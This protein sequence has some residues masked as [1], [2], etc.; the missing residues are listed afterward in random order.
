MLFS[1]QAA[2]R[3]AVTSAVAGLAIALAAPL[4]AD[5]A[6][7]AIVCNAPY[8]CIQTYSVSSQDAVI[9]AWADTES[10]YG[11]FYAD[12]YVGY[13]ITEFEFS[14]IQT[15]PAGGT[16]YSFTLDCSSSFTYNVQA[17]DEDTGDT[18][19]NINFTIHSC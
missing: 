13:G 7:G 5:A 4:P 10:F 19:G 14:N 9:H 18:I 1:K 2:A 12:V 6:A 15:W 17:I 16:H 8:L 11:Y 3:V